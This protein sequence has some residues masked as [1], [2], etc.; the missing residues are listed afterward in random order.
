MIASF[1]TIL[2]CQLIGEAIAHGFD[3][4]L[5]GPVI[6]MALML[7]A[8]AARDRFKP[9]LPAPL[10]DGTLEGVA[11]AILAQ[12]SLL[13]VPAGVGVIQNLHVLGHYG[14]ALIAALL[15]STLAALL[16]TVW[17]FVLVARRVAGP[18]GEP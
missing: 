17:T 11:R 4:P 3:L 6:G 1:A 16:A 7:A 15:V 10:A 18:E 14:L 5:P 13:F 8:L 2:L 9:R 12:L